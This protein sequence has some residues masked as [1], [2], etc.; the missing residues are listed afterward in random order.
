M[1]SFQLLEGIIM[2]INEANNGGDIDIFI[3]TEKNK[4]LWY[5]LQAKVL[6]IE[7][8]YE[9]LIAKS[10][11]KSLANLQNSSGCIPFYLFF[12]GI[13]KKAG[14]NEDCCKHE[15]SEK[16]F[17][18]TLVDIDKV[19]K[20]ATDRSYPRYTDFYPKNGHPWRELVCCMARR[21]EG[22]LFSLRQIQNTVSYYSGDVNSEIIFR[23]ADTDEIYGDNITAIRNSN[24]RYD[25]NPSHN[26]VI[27][28]RA[29]MNQNVL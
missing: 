11:W 7:G 5:A 1:I 10:Q 28:S 29:G 26:F 18:C 19:A 8:R 22:T 2:G 15:I 4:F 20:I 27:R 3:K 17:G 25:R 23:G 13:D 12:N 21:R 14:T 16:Q 24:T 9:R 6:K